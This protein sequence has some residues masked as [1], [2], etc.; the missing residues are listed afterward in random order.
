MGNDFRY[1]RVGQGFR[2]FVGLH[3]KV[4]FLSGMLG[5]GLAPAG[6]VFKRKQM[7]YL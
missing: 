6:R 4:F 1:V 5:G 7:M 3:E 2:G